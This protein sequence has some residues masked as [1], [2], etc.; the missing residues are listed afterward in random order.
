MPVLTKSEIHA[1]LLNYLAQTFPLF[2]PAAPD[3]VPIAEH[4]VD[5]LGTTNIVVHLENDF[6]IMIDD[7]EITRSNLGSVQS[8]VN[9]V[10]KKMNG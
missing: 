4:G 9:F 6:E 3:T 5:S 8:L 10:D 1:Q 7:S 2:N